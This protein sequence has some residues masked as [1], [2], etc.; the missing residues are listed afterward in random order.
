ML[1]SQ[2]PACALRLADAQEL[3]DVMTREQALI[4]GHADLRFTGRIALTAPTKDGL[5]AEL[6]QRN[7][8]QHSPA[9]RPGSCSA[10][11]HS[12]SPTPHSPWQERSTENE[13]RYRTHA[14]ILFAPTR[15]TRRRRRSSRMFANWD[16]EDIST[17][18]E[19][20]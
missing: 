5:D 6:S 3:E 8:P 2:H 9:A 16:Q 20:S 11:R 14:T 15:L 7:A 4:S 19:G 10:S 12:P 18:A 17:S 1:S 13:Q